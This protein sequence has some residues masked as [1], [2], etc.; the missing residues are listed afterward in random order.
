MM[1]IRHMYLKK[2]LRGSIIL[3]IN[4]ALVGLLG[5]ILRIFLARNLS[6]ASFGLFYAVV[7]L[8]MFFTTFLDL[9]L[10]LAVSKKIIELEARKMYDR[11]NNL[12]FSVILFQL[13]ISLLIMLGIILFAGFLSTSY[14]HADAKVLM[15]I[16][17]VWLVTVPFVSLYSSIFYGFQRLELYGALDISKA[18]LVLIFSVML[19][20]VGNGIYGLA[21]AYFISN[22]LLLIIFYFFIKKVFKQFSLLN[23]RWDKTLLKEVLLFGVTLSIASFIWLLMVQVDT[24]VLTYFTNTVQVGL[25]QVA[26]LISNLVLLLANAVSAAMFPTISELYMKKDH[27]RLSQGISSAY[28]YLSL[29][30]FPLVLL[31]VMFPD[32]IIN[33][34]F[35]SKFLD[36]VPA[37]VILAIGTI[38][39][40]ITTIN[41]SI[42]N[43]FNKP[44][45]VIKIMGAVVVFNM[46]LLFILVPR[47][48]L[49][50]A[51]ISTS[52]SFVIASI[53]SSYHLQKHISFK[54]PFFTWAVL[55]PTSILLIFVVNWLRNNL[56]MSLWPKLFIIVGICGII[57][58]LVLHIF[59]IF[60]ISQ[61]KDLMTSSK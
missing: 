60:R 23:G 57:Y 39:T 5:Y 55:I 56:T 41:N 27:T 4:A 43:A 12:F 36:A 35:T 14:F 26:I 53:L 61:I 19:F 31:V 11:I 45:L 47:Y 33:L 16:L 59:K 49:F 2:V 8:F 29:V 15:Y 48:G 34:F 50:G 44:S 18:L 10:S 28:T 13:V 52:T 1:S 24:L 32:I 40:S 51:A 17:M 38:F 37:L 46:V 30:L 22:I 20:W 7:T 58:F 42:L 9:G 54:L 6:I 3:L 25:Y 21:F